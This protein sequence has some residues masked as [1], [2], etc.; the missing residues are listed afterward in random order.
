MRTHKHPKREEID[1]TRVLY[2]L[3]DPIRI[4]IVLTLAKQGTATCAELDAGRPK[5][6]M[7]HHFR[8]LREAGLIRT[9]PEGTSHI[10]ELRRADIDA[11]FPGLLKSIL[12]A[13]AEN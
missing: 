13:V 9:T 10:N 7:S 12:K 1:L 3:S 8:A 4:E 5:S 2:A 11:R 6:S